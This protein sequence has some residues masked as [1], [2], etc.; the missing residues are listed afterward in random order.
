MNV[1]YVLFQFCKTQRRTEKKKREKN[2]W[3][4]IM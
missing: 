1:F 2:S 3:D 4:A